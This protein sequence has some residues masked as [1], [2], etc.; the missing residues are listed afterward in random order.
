MFSYSKKSYEYVRE[1]LEHA[2]PSISTI[3]NWLNKVDGSPGLSSQA[4]QQLKK[5]VEEKKQLGQN[6]FVNFILDEMHIKQQTW[7][8]GKVI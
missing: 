6:L 1:T 8:N 4:F 7:F 2:L 3:R 5:M